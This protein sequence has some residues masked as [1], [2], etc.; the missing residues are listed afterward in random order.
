ME[1]KWN[2]ERKMATHGLSG[3]AWTGR[4]SWILGVIFAV[5]GVVG[6]AANTT[7]GLAP[8]SWY[9]LSIAAFVSG[10]GNIV[11]WAA[12]LILWAKESKGK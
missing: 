12:G 4:I 6:E 7:L 5:V 3:H 10:V 11:A 1:A 8:T 2:K 9:L